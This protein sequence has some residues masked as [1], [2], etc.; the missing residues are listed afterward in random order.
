MVRH[1]KEIPPGYLMTLPAAHAPRPD[2][3]PSWNTTLRFVPG[4]Q[5][6]GL[7]WENSGWKLHCVGSV[8]SWVAVI[9]FATCWQSDAPIGVAASEAPSGSRR[10][11]LMGW[12]VRAVQ[13]ASSPSA[14]SGKP[15]DGV[16]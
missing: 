8:R 9:T 1:G 5:V 10:T 12:P 13:E 2:P 16:R 6:P 7:S 11:L 4:P 3:K 14:N 15:E